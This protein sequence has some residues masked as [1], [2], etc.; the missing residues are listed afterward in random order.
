MGDWLWLGPWPATRDPWLQD[1][2]AGGV[3]ASGSSLDF[4]YPSEQG[5]PAEVIMMI[6]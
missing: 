2:L 1:A 6:R 4:G 3:G 5:C